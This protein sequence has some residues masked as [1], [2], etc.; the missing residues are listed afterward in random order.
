MAFSTYDDLSVSLASRLA[1]VSDLGEQLAKAIQDWVAD[2]HYRVEAAIAENRLSWELRLCVDEQ[3]PL[4]KWG[5]IF[6]NAISDLRSTLNNVLWGVAEVE[7]ITLEKPKLVQ[8]PIAKTAS[9]W[10]QQA[11]W[12]AELPVATQEA[13]HALQPFQRSGGVDGTP[14]SD[15]LL[16]LQR[17]SNTDKHRVALLP[18]VNPEEL[19]HTFAV[20]FHTEED[21]SAQGEPQVAINVSFENG[22]VLL[23]QV[24]TRPIA[25]VKG[26]HEF[27]ARAVVIQ[28]PH[29]PVPLTGGL[30]ALL[31]YVNQVSAVVLNATQARS[32]G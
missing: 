30:S 10:T 14:D 8:F 13:V 29:Q 1:H 21:A 4:G 2:G 19:A 23:R 3:P 25:K 6:A 20:E 5:H 15:P 18:I 9:D 22:A 32:T 16:L 7:G 12:V 17:L 31:Q 24:T 28:P 26:S 27:K 11:R